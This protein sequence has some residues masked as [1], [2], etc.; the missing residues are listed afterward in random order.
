MKKKMFGGK[1]R[2]Y[3]ESNVYGS[4]TIEIIILIINAHNYLLEFYFYFKYLLDIIVTLVKLFSHSK[5]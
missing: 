2:S 1:A 4:L 3:T 5:K